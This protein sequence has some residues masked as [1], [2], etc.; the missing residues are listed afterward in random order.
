M[1]EREGSFVWS[2]RDV[3]EGIRQ[4]AADSIR[5]TRLLRNLNWR[6]RGA[7]TKDRGLQ[8][9]VPIALLNGAYSSYGG[10]DAHFNNGTQKVMVFQD[11]GTNGKV[12]I[13]SGG[14]LE[15]ET[16]TLARTKPCPN[17]I[18]NQVILAD[19]TSL[20]AWDG[21]TWSTPGTAD[22]NGCTFGVVYANRLILFG[23]STYPYYFYPS[24][25][26]DP[27]D[28][29]A[30]L[31]YEV[32]GTRGEVITGA[33]VC[34]SHLIVGGEGFCRAFYLGTAS[35]RD[36]DWDGLSE[37]IG[38]VN[39]QCFV[40]VTRNRGNDSSAFTFFWS[41][42]GPAM[43]AN[44]GGAPMLVPLW[45]PIQEMVWGQDYQGLDGLD[46]SY[47]SS[48]EAIYAPEYDE[49]RFCALDNA[50]NYILLCVDVD[51]AIR[52]AVDSQT[53][54]KWRIR[55]N[56]DM[57]FPNNY[58]PVEVDPDTSQP[59]TDGIR[60]VWC[61]RNGSLFQMDADDDCVDDF[62]QLIVAEVRR[63]GY[64]GVEDGIKE[65]DKSVRGC[66]VRCMQVG[67]YTLY[68][69]VYGDGGES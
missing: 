17:M 10:Y 46:T 28:W 62:D 16:V 19:G 25:V 5:H 66:Y 34:G 68:V 61:T 24:G 11:N 9:M 44:F 2:E 60:R 20:H 30:D 31:A 43:V 58:F 53:S 63:D 4:D 41:N 48:V 51:S 35:P 64:D 21:S 6:T 59:S 47:F 32:M 57:D 27:T 18:A 69:T 12:Y 23:D 50:G 45:R 37:Q 26:R 13:Y 56:T 36:W 65:R 39:W 7:L 33:G 52:S 3:T 67:R 49:V 54:P 40:E 42:E 14:T 15:D 55:D 22:V 29:D 8:R 1:I 38:P